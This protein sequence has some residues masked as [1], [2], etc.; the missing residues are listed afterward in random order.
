[1]KTFID[2]ICGM[3][4]SQDT[5]FKYNNGNETV[6]F[7]SKHCLETY[8]TQNAVTSE[9]KSKLRIYF[10][11]LLILGYLVLVTG[12]IEVYSS[13][14]NFSIWMYHFM[15]GFFVIFS[16]FKFLDLNGFVSAFRGYD[17]IAKKFP[18][19][20][21]SYPFIELI[22]GLG[23]ILKWNLIFLNWAT[24]IFMLVSSIGVIESLL[25]KNKIQCACLG[26]VFNLPMSTITVVEDLLMVGMAIFSLLY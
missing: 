15:G 25:K 5:P 3:Q 10:P 12:I 18:L 16:F 19:Y 20:G 4:V 9:S 8:E 2:P 7:C 14:P 6:Y 11:L 13:T 22:L 26:T 1:M 24:I 23:F 17:V 21:Y